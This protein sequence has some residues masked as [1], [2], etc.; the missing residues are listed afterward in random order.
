MAASE[1]NIQ[2]N[3]SKSR[4]FLGEKSEPES[5]KAKPLALR[6]ALILVINLKLMIS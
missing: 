2:I 3:P 1:G 5:V 4:K 6:F